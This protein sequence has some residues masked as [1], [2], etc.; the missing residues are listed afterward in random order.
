ML[1]LHAIGITP[2]AGLTL[3]NVGAVLP[4]NDGASQAGVPIDAGAVLKAWGGL[5][6]TADTIAA[7]QL[8]SQD[9]VDQQNGEYLTPGATNLGNAIWEWDNLPY[10]KGM[11]QFYMG[12]NTGVTAS[13]AFTLD[14]YKAMATKAVTAGGRNVAKQVIPP[15]LTFGGAVNGGWTSLAF[16]PVKPMPNGRYAIL[17]VK[18]SAITNLAL[19]RFQHTDFAGL[20]PGFAIVNSG[21]VSSSSFDKVPKDDLFL[22]NDG[23][24]FVHMSDVLGEP[25]CPVFTVGNNTTGLQIQMYSL[26]ADTP[27]VQLMLAQVG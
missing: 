23:N 10:V 11:R 13:L 16:A 8:L 5:S 27:V 6:P 7:L 3:G 9:M 1:D 18:V 19:I 12:T 4:G 21:I 15:S 20:S 25:V 17:G 24:Q 14:D 26:Q 2:G 22:T